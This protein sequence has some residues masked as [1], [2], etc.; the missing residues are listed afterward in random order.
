[1][2]C[3][4]E[5][6]SPYNVT[7]TDVR[8]V[9]QE[10]N[11]VIVAGGYSAIGGQ[12]SCG[13]AA[14]IGAPGCTPLLGAVAFAFVDDNC[15]D[16]YKQ[17]DGDYDATGVR[18]A[19]G[20][21]AMCWI[22]SQESAHDFGLDHAFGKFDSGQSTCNDPMT[23][24][25]DCGGQ[26]F[27]RND[28]APCNGND[29]QEKPACGGADECATK[30]NSHLQMLNGVGPSANGPITAKPVSTMVV[31]MPGATVM[32]GTTVIA[33]ASAQRGVANVQLWING[34]NWGETMGV[35]FGAAGQPEFAYSLPIPAG[36]P[37]SKLD[38]VMKAFDDLG[39]E[40]DS[41]VVSVIKG[42][43]AG[44][45]A[46]VMNPDGTVDTCPQGPGVHRRQVPVDR[47]RHGPVRRHLHLSAVLRQRRLP[48]HRDPADLHARLR[49]DDPRQL[50][51]GLHVHRERRERHL[52][53]RAAGER[54]LLQ[55]RQR[56]PARR[57][58]EPHHAGPPVRPSPEARAGVV[59]AA[60]LAAC[61]LAASA[62]A[63]RADLKIHYVAP[64]HPETQV[65][66][67]VL[68]GL[69][70]YLNRCEN[71]CNV[72]PGGNDATTDSSDIASMAA[73]LSMHAW[74]PGEW[75]GVVQ[76]VKEVYSPYNIKVTDTRPTDGQYNEVIVAGSAQAIG[77]I[78]SC[79]V[80]EF[81]VTPCEPTT[82]AVAFTFTEGGC[83]EA[84]AQEDPDPNGAAT[85]IFGTCWVIAQETAHSFSLD[86]EYEYQDT[87][88]SACND[89]MTY[90]SDCG[91]QK[92]FRNEYATCGEFTQ[93]TVHICG[94]ACGNTQNSHARLLAILGP[95]TP[96][97]QPPVISLV[98]PMD[99]AT[100]MAGTP[101][102]GIASAQRGIATVELWLN[103]YK[104]GSALG[105]DFGSRASRSRRTRS[106]SRRARPT[107]STTSC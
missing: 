70:L 75:E 48:G 28:F 41:Q 20:I 8:P 64:K 86:H 102:T 88:R 107:A 54:R 43:A 97:T 22:A 67:A 5:V 83:H 38:I 25:S 79:G 31:P 52:L 21:R 93:S 73:S 37:D 4:Q 47:C 2:K 99:G 77:A 61:A 6:Y 46:T 50:P 59:R 58:A 57:R 76:C 16:E 24:Q 105:V 56:W 87:M 13:L 55:R 90:R 85:G 32:A 80:G 100:V 60:I 101:A 65:H 30:Q 51:D 26:K 89:P 23:Y 104:W 3:V 12:P 39:I 49:S 95:G 69:Q 74:L 14:A 17:E 96:I 84:F 91:G 15:Y 45:D 94:G 10:F 72:H 34:Y 92:F 62:T 82:Q 66:P 78:D 29:G 35:A 98:T 33:K 1:M 27:F 81:S 36:V 18:L 106:R 42:K 9:G 11:E 71:G 68:T 53:H 7:V 103:G 40:G 63:A 44:C 19:T